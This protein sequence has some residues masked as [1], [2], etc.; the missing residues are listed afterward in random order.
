MTEPTPTP[1]EPPVAPATTDP[2]TTTARPSDDDRT[3]LPPRGLEPGA[4]GEWARGL[5]EHTKRRAA[6][7]ARRGEAEARDRAARAIR[8]SNELA[9]RLGAGELPVSPDA[10]TPIDDMDEVKAAV[11]R[12]AWLTSLQL[13]SMDAY[14]GRQIADLEPDQHPAE[15]A[16]Y[17]EHLA[18]DEQPKANLILVGRV[19][20]GKTTTA[21]AVGQAASDAGMLVRIVPHALYLAW[22]RP[23]GAPD[24]LEPHQIRA[25]YMD[26]DLTIIDDLGDELDL[27]A[28]AKEFVRRETKLLI[29]GR[30]AAGRPT[31]YTTNLTGANI[32]KVLGNRTSSRIGARAVVL[33]FEGPDRRQPAAW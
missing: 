6:E 12:R 18:S 4:L 25:R 17:V 22:L 11:R 28:E 2:S 29:G 9:E 31:I 33:K 30:E 19:G 5:I 23:G 8:L 16:A 24:G 21:C 15:V 26:A 7:E 1:E 32:D 27:D 10:V 14:A 13:A 20:P 3:P